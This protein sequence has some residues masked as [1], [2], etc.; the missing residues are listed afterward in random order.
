MK[1]RGERLEGGGDEGEEFI[2]GEDGD[3]ELAAFFEFCR[4]HVLS[5]ENE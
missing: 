1:G 5:G 4:S 3:A 2:F